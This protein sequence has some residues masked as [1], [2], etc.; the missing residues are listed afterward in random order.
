MDLKA[1]RD[2]R[3]YLRSYGLTTK[4]KLFESFIQQQKDF[5]G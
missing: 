2:K 3:G 4:N 1:N 5:Q